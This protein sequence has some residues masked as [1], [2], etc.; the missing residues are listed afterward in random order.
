MH[1]VP[2]NLD[3]PTSYAEIY[4]QVLDLLTTIRSTQG[5]ESN[6]LNILL[7]PG[8]PTMQAV[9]VLLAKTRFPAV[10]WSGYQGQYSTVELPF[11]IELEFIEQAQ[12]NADRSLQKAFDTESV[13]KNFDAIVGESDVIRSQ[14]HKAVKLSQRNVPTLILGPTGSGKE[15]FARAIHEASP[16]SNG[17]FV[18]INCGA[19]PKELAESILFGH[20]RGAFTGASSDQEGL[21]KLADKGT[22]F[23]DEVGE[24]TLD[25]QV[26]LLRVLQEKVFRPL[27]AKKDSKSDFRIIAATHQNL[28]EKVADGTF[29]EDLFY[30]IAIGMIKLPALVERDNDIELLSDYLLQSINQE[31]ADQPGYQSKKFNTKVKKVIKSHAWPGNIRELRATILRVCA[32]SDNREITTEEFEEA[33]IKRS[34]KTTSLLLED[35]SQGVDLEEKVNELQTH[36]ILK[37]STLT[38]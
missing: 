36:Y 4:P 3:N 19:L 5:L 10:C 27:G 15:V 17:E 1:P 11:N 32:W 23:L 13:L 26:K 9:W 14:V 35:I 30:R 38:A 24:L 22:L 37:A 20:K 18:A 21:V 31:L 8:T 2:A 12:R 6:Q 25:L 16:Q 28:L 7:S 29:R 33:I 34:T